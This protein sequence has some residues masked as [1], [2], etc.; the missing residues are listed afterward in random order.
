MHEH[1]GVASDG[2]GDQLVEASL[3]GCMIGVTLGLM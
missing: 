2:S 3:D 1:T